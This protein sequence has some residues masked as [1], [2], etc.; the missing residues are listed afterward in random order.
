MRAT[1]EARNRP[2]KLVAGGGAAVAQ[3]GRGL[4]PPPRVTAFVTFSSSLR[5]RRGAVGEALPRRGE[6]LCADGAWR[7]RERGVA[8]AAL[9]RE[10]GE[11]GVGHIDGDDSLLDL[12]RVNLGRTGA[13][14][15]QDYSFIRSK[16]R[17]QG[18]TG[19]AMAAPKKKRGQSGASRVAPAHLHWSADVLGREHAQ[20]SVVRVPLP[21]LPS[22]NIES[23]LRGRADD[24]AVLR[25]GGGWRSEGGS[26]RRSG[27][28]REVW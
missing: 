20:H 7:R 11:V 26:E 24:A 15:Q 28:E 6:E 16:K 8:G 3:E 10:A 4:R 25:K 22:L 23:A 14:R 17:K 27:R 12:H 5:D 18:R 2:K 21:D 13:E 9:G 19:R 1:D